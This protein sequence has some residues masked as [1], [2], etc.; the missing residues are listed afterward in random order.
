MDYSRF[1]QYI[2]VY[3]ATA[4]RGLRRPSKRYVRF[5]KSQWTMKYK[6]KMKEEEKEKVL[7]KSGIRVCHQVVHATT[8]GDVTS[9]KETD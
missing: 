4:K 2:L 8:L 9:Q 7:E 6:K 3:E 5:E 1:P